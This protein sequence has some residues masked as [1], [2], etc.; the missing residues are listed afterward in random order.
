[1]CREKDVAALEH[2]VLTHAAELSGCVCVFIAWDEPRQ[3]LVKGLLAR[4]VPLRV[5][6]VSESAQS[7]PMGVMEAQP[8]NFHVLPL[9]QVAAKLAFL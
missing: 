5:L 4:R 6:V 9:G 1:M 3:R 8:E 2:L 7:W